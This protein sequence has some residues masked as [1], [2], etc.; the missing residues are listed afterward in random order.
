[1][2]VEQGDEYEFVVEDAVEE[3]VVEDRVPEDDRVEAPSEQPIG[4]DGVRRGSGVPRKGGADG[5]RA[6]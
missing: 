4:A 5:V 6:R 1:M 3:G 2:A